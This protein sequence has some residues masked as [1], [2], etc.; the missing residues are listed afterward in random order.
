MNWT[1]GSLSRS[2]KQNASLSVIQKRHFARARGKL[3]NGRPSPQQI[4]IS[5]FH[6]A[7]SDDI[8]PRGGTTSAPDPCG[9]RQSTQMTLGD[10]ESLRPVVKQLQSLRPHRSPKTMLRSHFSQPQTQVRYH[11]DYQL[12]TKKPRS[13]RPTIPKRA[14][15]GATKSATGDSITPT[16]IDEL[17][18]KR[19]ELLATFD[20][21]GLEKMK[22]VKIYFANAED[23]DLIG[24][25]RLVKGNHA[26]EVPSVPQH[27]RRLANAHDKLNMMRA[28]SQS[29]SSPGKISIHI[30]SSR[31]GSSAGRRHSKSSNGGDDSQAP[32]SDEM[33]LDDHESFTGAEGASALTTNAL[34]RYT[35]TSDD[36]LFDPG[37]SD[38]A[39]QM[40]ID[41]TASE[42]L[43]HRQAPNSA[44]NMFSSSS[45]SEYMFEAR[46]LE[47]TSDYRRSRRRR[48]TYSAHVRS[49]E[50]SA[51]LNPSKLGRPNPNQAPIF[52][53]PNLPELNR[54]GERHSGVERRASLRVNHN[55]GSCQI[56]KS[57]S[58]STGHAHEPR[59][60]HTKAQDFIEPLIPA[61]FT[62][63]D[64]YNTRKH[65]QLD[66]QKT[67]AISEKR[68]KDM[69]KPQII[70]K[71]QQRLSHI[72][73]VPKPL[74]P[75]SPRPPDQ[76]NRANIGAPE[77][78]ARPLPPALE[79][80]SPTPEQA[81]KPQ[82]Q[83]DPTPEEDE[84]LWRKFVFGTEN[85]ANDWTFD[86]EAITHPLVISKPQRTTNSSS[87]LQPIFNAANNSVPNS[88]GP[89]AQ[90]QPSLLVEASSSPSPSLPPNDPQDVHTNPSHSHSSSGP[91]ETQHSI[92]AHASTSP[93]QASNTSSDPL[94]YSP[95]RLLHPPVTFRKPNRYVGESQESVTPVRLGVGRGKRKRRGRE[96]DGEDG[97]G[98]DE[99]ESQRR[100]KGRREWAGGLVEEMDVGE[101]E[102]DEIVD[103]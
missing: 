92:Q 82:A 58:P 12:Q 77:A 46:E 28:T 20:W 16:T 103:D 60:P 57:S 41:P 4:D 49:Q 51:A 11:D 32:A 8:M 101:G 43:L 3:L 63:G 47:E 72:A 34:R 69:S 55:T 93:L 85:P 65:E 97:G 17:E 84:L 66:T 29:L 27:R 30:G 98:Y 100:K 38:G 91:P 70:E 10:F 42:P 74:T 76:D 35:N 53:Y 2:R 62:D 94:S 86:E 21:V 56:I 89:P 48:N 95:S 64:S 90:T 50:E 75:H 33:L 39:S 54:A 83:A 71:E 61:R 78:S 15:E 40:N 44:T 24:K 22:P 18:A 9:E 7:E 25:R 13:Q 14:D 26:A 88:D 81:N 73:D 87:P 79:L 5:I 52:E 1:G 37:W 67:K 31:R 68:H 36:M 80:Q 19:R 59:S 6:D 23:R 96:V 45:E 102:G 99:R